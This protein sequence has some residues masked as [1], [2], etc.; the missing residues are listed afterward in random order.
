MKTKENTLT[1]T[2]SAIAKTKA[3][4]MAHDKADEIVRNIA[5]SL[6]DAWYDDGVNTPALVHLFGF[7]MGQSMTKRP[8]FSILAQACKETLG[9]D[10]KLSTAFLLGIAEGNATT[11]GDKEQKSAKSAV[12]QALTGV[13]MESKRKGAGGPTAKTP[14]ESFISSIVKSTLTDEELVLAFKT[15]MEARKANRKATK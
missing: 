9:F 7:H 5:Q 8:T 14:G 2:Q 1:L 10:R 6:C 4:A 11:W 12:S 3:C 15:A 13:G